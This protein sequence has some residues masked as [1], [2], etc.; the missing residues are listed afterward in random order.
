MCSMM[1]GDTL[2]SVAREVVYRGMMSLPPDIKISRSGTLVREPVG[3]TDIAF[4]RYRPVDLLC[5]CSLHNGRP[6]P[7]INR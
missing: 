5:E 4:L 6:P 2:T 3:S 1:A 7:L